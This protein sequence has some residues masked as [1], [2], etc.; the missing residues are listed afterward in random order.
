MFT[1]FEKNLYNVYLK[2][3]RGAKNQP[4]KKRKNFEKVNE[5]I[6][7]CLKKLAIFFNN[8]KDVNPSDFFKAP[9]SIYPEGE[10]FDLKFYTTQ[11][12]IKVYKIFLDSKKVVDKDNISD[13]LRIVTEK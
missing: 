1:D 6:S 7:L 5:T 11:R 2:E 10:T 8:N 4:Y 13:K 9:Y 3:L 12:A